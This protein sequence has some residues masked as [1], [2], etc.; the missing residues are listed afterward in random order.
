MAEHHDRFAELNKHIPL[1]D[2]IVAAHKSI[3]E[4]LPFVVRVAIAIYDPDTNI[5]KTYLHSSGGDNPLDHYQASLDDAP[6]LKAILK[7]GLPRVVNNML[8]FEDGQNEHTKRIGRQGYAASYTLPMF[9]N[10]NFFGFIFF[11]SN[12]QDVFTEDVLRQIDVR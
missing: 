9:N 4:M 12:K 7:K 1:R 5:L 8:T 2:K 10:G 11:N 3:S 6:S